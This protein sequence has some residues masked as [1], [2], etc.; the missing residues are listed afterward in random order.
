M[1]GIPQLL[2]SGAS[3]V[4]SALPI[5]VGVG[6]LGYLYKKYKNSKTYKAVKDKNAAEQAW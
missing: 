6:G 2:L 5:L 3:V 1:T 4:G